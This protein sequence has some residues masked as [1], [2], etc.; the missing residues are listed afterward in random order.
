MG[1]LPGVSSRGSSRVLPRGCRTA[2]LS[3]VVSLMLAACGKSSDQPAAK[4][5]IVARIGGEVVTTQELENE[6][7][8]ENVPPARQGDPETVRKVLNELVLRKY[9]LQQAVV[10]R[11]DREPGVLLDMLRAHDQVLANAVIARAV[12]AKPPGKADIDDYIARNLL[13]FAKRKLLGVEQVGFPLSGADQATLDAVKSAGSLDEAEQKLAASAVPHAR[14]ASLLNTGDVPQE[15]ADAMAGKGIGNLFFIRSG[16]NGVLFQ[17]RSEQPRPLEGEAAAE[18]ARQQL[19]AEAMKAEAGLAGMSAKLE[20]KY[21]GDYARIMM[22]AHASA[23]P[24]R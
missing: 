5:Q 1:R 24:A 11:L 23:E 16:A 15:L 12:A 19:R 7:R 3:V 2:A 10:A 17:I 21:E 9:L 20:A 4:S 8:W 22:G 13:R 14:Q 6:F 18:F